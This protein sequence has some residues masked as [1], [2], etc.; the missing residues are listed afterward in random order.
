ML[1]TEDIIKLLGDEI[2]FVFRCYTGPIQGLNFRNLVWHGFLDS[3][4]L[5]KSYTAFLLMLTM[6]LRDIPEVKNML[7]THKR[8]KLENLNQFVHSLSFSISQNPSPFES[9]FNK[10]F[11]NSL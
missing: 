2:A 9:T 1:V 11:V 6:S 8:R 4:T 5:D 7:A 3:E 10:E